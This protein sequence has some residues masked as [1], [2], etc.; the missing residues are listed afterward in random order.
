MITPPTKLRTAGPQL[1]G[2]SGLKLGDQIREFAKLT[3]K[4]IGYVHKNTAQ[5]LFDAIVQDTPV[6]TGQ[7]RGSWRASMGAPQSYGPT[8]PDKA[9][10]RVKAEIEVEITDDHEKV[11]Y[12]SSYLEYIIPLE[13]GWSSKSP[14][15]MVRLNIMRF[16]QIMSMQIAIAK[17]YI[18]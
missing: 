5:A 9:G 8:L 14:E 10:S 16:E 2:K 3:D 7:A 1:P 11:A 4:R 17:M 6:D 13:Y 18:K 15:G 12:L